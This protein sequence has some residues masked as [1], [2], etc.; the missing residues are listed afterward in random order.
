MSL[1]WSLLPIKP[2]ILG[3]FLSIAFNSTFFVNPLTS[4]ILFSTVVN[5]AFVTKLLTSG[6]SPSI[7]VVLTS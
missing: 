5:A 7:S 2:V 6:V 1:S 3:I 4:S